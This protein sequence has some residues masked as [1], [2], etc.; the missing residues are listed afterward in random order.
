MIRFAPGTSI[1]YA[2]YE[3]ECS[4][5]SPLETRRR[6]SV[7]RWVAGSSPAR[8]ANFLN[9]LDLLRIPPHRFGQ[10]LG[11]HSANFGLRSSPS[12]SPSRRSISA[13]QIAAVHP[14]FVG[15]V[16]YQGPRA[17]IGKLFV[18]NDI[19][20]R[21]LWRVVPPWPRLPSRSPRVSSLASSLNAREPVSIELS[22]LGD[23]RW[24]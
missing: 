16:T 14:T 8:G 22:P 20:A 2:T 9:S 13:A 6:M 24:W 7:N 21:R 15:A 23:F 3:P 4:G 11:Q 19:Y 12:T 5:V 17:L 18:A 1:I 10:H